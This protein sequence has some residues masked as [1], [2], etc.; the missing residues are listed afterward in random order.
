MLE[1]RVTLRRVTSS[2]SVTLMEAHVAAHGERQRTSECD[3][4][5]LPQQVLACAVLL[6]AGEEDE[7]CGPSEPVQRDA[8]C[9]DVDAGKRRTRGTLRGPAPGRAAPCPGRLDFPAPSSPPL[10]QAP[11][12]TSILSHSCRVLVV[13]E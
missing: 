4:E 12:T 11:P 7:R 6:Q 9:G 10:S 3:R 8:A 5:Q 1:L 2:A 13:L